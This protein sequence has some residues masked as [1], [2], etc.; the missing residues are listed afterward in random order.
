MDHHFLY[1]TTV[2]HAVIL[3]SESIPTDHFICTVS[4]PK[5]CKCDMSQNRVTCI[6]KENKLSYIP[7]I[8]EYTHLER[9]KFS[10]NT[11]LRLSSASFINLTTWSVKYLT[12]SDNNIVS[13]SEDSFSGFPNLTHLDVSGNWFSERTDVN[14]FIRVV[15]ENIKHSP[16][17]KIKL[18]Y[19]LRGDIQDDV[20]QGLGDLKK[21]KVISL[22]RN[23]LRFFNDTVFRDLEK[24]SVIDVSKN[25]IEH[26]NFAGLPSLTKLIMN[27]NRLTLKKYAF[28]DENGYPKYPNLNTLDLRNN[29]IDRLDNT[30]FSCMKQLKSLYLDK[31]RVRKIRN[32]TFAEIISLKVL[33]MRSMSGSLKAIHGL[34]FNSSS[35]E[36]L[37]LDGN[38]F[39]FRDKYGV[40]DFEKIFKW[41]PNLRL[42]NLS[43]NNFVNISRVQFFQ[44]LSPLT[45]LHTLVLQ[46]SMIVNIPTKVF[47][48]LSSL[49]TLNLNGNKFNGWD[50]SVFWNVHNLEH[51]SME[52]C[53]IYF[54][55][56]TS[57]PNHVISS[58][59]TVSFAYNPFSCT[60]DLLWLKEWIKNSSIRFIDYPGRYRCSF[61]TEWNGRPIKD[62][63]PSDIHCSL[64][65]EVGYGSLNGYLFDIIVAVLESLGTNRDYILLMLITIQY[66]VLLYKKIN[67]LM[68]LVNIIKRCRVVVY[69]A[70]MFLVKIIK[71]CSVVVYNFITTRIH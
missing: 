32:N 18:N 42:L 20:L 33:S 13:L 58:L 28:C 50:S 16:L 12:I 22:R 6:G 26:Y 44:M 70:L 25:A 64:S 60:C 61:P 24:I 35:L 23:T 53:N 62:Y 59:K 31:N 29:L 5:Q 27:K 41:C 21:L 57:F 51:L 36:K 9:F 43:N 54:F 39:A 55:N 10:N 40:F 49:R 48:H 4:L 1:L 46:A 2:L 30:S 63:D 17:H 68:F 15:L 14:R 66:L 56:E 65:N 71:R 45:N 52:G 34:A 67:A 47:G 38:G 7:A 37:Y 69:N 3:V 19:V 8:P 11:L